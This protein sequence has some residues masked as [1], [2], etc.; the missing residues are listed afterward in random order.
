MNKILNAILFIIIVVAI[1]WFII[2]LSPTKAEVDRFFEKSSCDS[3]PSQSW[4]EPKDLCSYHLRRH[5]TLLAGQIFSVP[6]FTFLFVHTP[7]MYY[8]D[9]EL[10]KD[11]EDMNTYIWVDTKDGR[12]VYN[13]VNGEYIK[14]ID[15][16]IDPAR[17]HIQEQMDYVQK[18]MTLQEN[19]ECNYN[20]Y[21]C[22]DFNTRA[23][24]QAVMFA[25][26]SQGKG[27]IHYLDG[28][29]DGIACESLP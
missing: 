28:D 6:M 16:K 27:D 25:C 7:F 15:D 19:A 17:K 24:A 9:M 4:Y 13:A 2:N 23:E 3:L 20:A 12:L 10:E 5:T 22:D 18:M 1:F 8:H 26:K 29:D 14:E 21:N 11:T